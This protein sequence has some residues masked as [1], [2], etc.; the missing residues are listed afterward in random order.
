MRAAHLSLI[1]LCIAAS[2]M[3][4]AAGA[5]QGAPPH[6][7][8]EEE[9]LIWHVL[10]RVT[11]GPRPGDVEQIASTGISVFI[12]QQLSPEPDSEPALEAKFSSLK[13]YSG[14][15]LELYRSH[16]DQKRMNHGLPSLGETVESEPVK[17][18][19]L[20]EL[21]LAKVVRAVESRWQ[22]KEVLIDF[23]S[24]HFN[25]DASKG[26]VSVLK[27]RDDIEVIR[28]KVLGSFR[29]LL[30]A[31]AKSPAMLFYLDQS[32]LMEQPDAGVTGPQSGSAIENY[33]RELLELH[34]LGV[35]GG[36]TQTDVQ[37]VA[38]CFTGWGIDQATGTFLFSPEKHDQGRK[39]VLGQEI[40][41][42]GGLSDGERVLQILS[43][44]PSTANFI[45]RALCR[46]FVSDDP[47]EA[48]VRRVAATFLET[49]GD[50][51]RVVR[52][53]LS[54]PEF[55]S[56]SVYGGKIKSPLELTVSSIRALD[57]Q[58]VVD[59]VAR[60]RRGRNAENARH[61]LIGLLAEMGQNLFRCA[62]P[63]GY[64]E[65][66]R[67]WLGSGALLARIRFVLA[68]ARNEISRVN[69]PSKILGT[70]DTPSEA[71]ADMLERSI[72]RFPPSEKLSAIVRKAA[73]RVPP[74]WRGKIILALLLGSPEFQSR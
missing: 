16:L 64:S 45:S 19:A 29:D 11:F 6:A 15:P 31:S 8:L 70:P 48:L 68:L 47:P 58:I 40:A 30:V 42:N 9:R 25:I 41:S 23:W 21:Q 67:R 36:Y 33:A 5:D 2:A 50:L 14:S 61:D 43:E 44:H 71:L 12:D 22:I 4:G 55:L 26:A 34:T 10:N 72:L 24:N 38:R 17:L 37:E 27:V 35:N 49:S 56:S 20:E 39:L 60:P 7:T 74:E 63:T 59:D 54:S 73:A 65:D 51:R 53:I 62:P 13:F 66:S 57:G 1:S 69:Y 3:A 18:K 52:T 32:R 28:P 46:R